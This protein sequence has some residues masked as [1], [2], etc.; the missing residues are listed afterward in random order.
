[1]MRQFLTILRERRSH[2]HGHL[3]PTC[4]H[5]MRALPKA[6]HRILSLHY[7]ESLEREPDGWCCHLLYGWTTDALCGGGTII[8]KDLSLIWAF[9]KDGYPVAGAEGPQLLAE[10]LECRNR[11][12]P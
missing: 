10:M 11:S 8:E 12:N 3:L 5:N 2:S 9:V 7:V 1:M 6:A 4:H